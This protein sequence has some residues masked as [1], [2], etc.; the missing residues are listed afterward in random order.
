MSRE[1][2]V[3]NLSIPDRTAEKGLASNGRRVS[4]VVIAFS[5]FSYQLQ[6]LDF[7]NH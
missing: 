1:E 2:P 7:P 3:A 6:V 4:M 5:P